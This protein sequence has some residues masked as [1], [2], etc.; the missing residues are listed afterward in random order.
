MK[1]LMTRIFSSCMFWYFCGIFIFFT[2][3]W[4]QFC[5]HLI[6]NW[7]FLFFC[8]IFQISW[9]LL[10]MNNPDCEKE[11]KACLHLI[12]KNIITIICHLSLSSSLS[13]PYLFSHHALP[14][15]NKLKNNFKT[16]STR[17]HCLLV[18][19]YFPM[20]WLRRFILQKK[21]VKNTC[22]RD[23]VICT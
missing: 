13:K 21:Y 2:C 4:I 5:N 1:V 3:I 12:W 8:L 10:F 22:L 16:S 18:P 23:V 14:P 17:D 15:K 19:F 7:K 20:C 11:S 6:Q 9:T